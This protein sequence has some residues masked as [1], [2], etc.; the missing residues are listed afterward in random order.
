MKV[1]TEAEM[2]NRMAAYCSGTERSTDDVRK[3]LMDADLSPE[4]AQRIID[5]LTSEQ[6]IDEARYARCFVNDKLRFNHWGKIRISNELRMKRL[7]ASYIEEALALIN[8]TEYQTILRN[9]LVQKRKSV[10]GKDDRDTT[11]KLIRFAVGRGF[12][13]RDII[14]CL[15][16]TGIEPD[17][18]TCYSDDLA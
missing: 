3:K 12:A 15:R 2:L 7:P 8:D 13:M 5:R 14:A 17:D 18:E 9:L 1:Y 10:K 6:F 16:Q 11:N 4:A